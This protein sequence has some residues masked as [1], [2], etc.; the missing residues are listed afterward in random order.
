MR[1]LPIEKQLFENPANRKTEPENLAKRKK[2]RIRSIEK[3][4]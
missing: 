2:R 4:N 1:S 3:K